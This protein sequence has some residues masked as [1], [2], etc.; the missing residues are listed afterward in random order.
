MMI[1]ERIFVLLDRKGMTQKEFSKQTGISQST[2]SEW[3]RKNTNPSADK[4]LKIC[5]V[6][7]VTPY[8][9][10]AESTVDKDGDIDYVIAL[11]EKEEV[12]LEKFRN[13][14]SRQKERLLG[15][16]DALQ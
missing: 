7:H 12:V 13:L 4:I 8:E 14:D 9:L 11:N 15:Y 16:M 5:E 3:K 6:L 10:L 1:S 2:I